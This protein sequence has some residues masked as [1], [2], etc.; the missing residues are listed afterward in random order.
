MF[1][2]KSQASDFFGA[3]TTL[4]P[5]QEARPIDKSFVH[6]TSKDKVLITDV[7]RLPDVLH[8]ACFADSSFAGVYVGLASPNLTCEFCF[9]HPL[10]HYPL[11]ML[12]EIGRQFGNAVSHRHYNIPLN[13]Y[14][15]IADTLLFNFQRFT[16]LDLPLYVICADSQI[17]NRKSMHQRHSD[18][19]FLQ[20]GAECVS[21]GGGYS[22]MNSSAYRRFRSNSR[23][24]LVHH[25]V[26]DPADIPTN[27][28][29]RH[30]PHERSCSTSGTQPPRPERLLC[31]RDCLPYPSRPG[32]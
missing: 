29:L 7:I 1:T 14:I 30:L 25:P 32:A 5:Q 19:S 17:T 3:V 26:R 31:Q 21:G 20:A 11:M 12:I 10:D 23:S 18:F 24:E 22:I 8:R 13:G 9:D 28:D 16:E 2:S 27:L 4:L 6:K 15:G